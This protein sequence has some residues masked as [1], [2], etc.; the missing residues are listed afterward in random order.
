M[1]RYFTLELKVAAE[2][3]GGEA[4]LSEREG[5]LFKKHADYLIS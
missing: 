2:E 4:E 3:N 1:M 5:R